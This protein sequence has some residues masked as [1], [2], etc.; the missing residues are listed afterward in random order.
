M[1]VLT[2][3]PAADRA[4]VG[5]PRRAARLRAGAWLPPLIV[6]IAVIGAWYAFSYAVLPADIRFLLPPPHQVVQVGYLDPDNFE[7]MLAALWS[8]TLVAVTGLAIAIVLGMAAGI[9]MSQAR[10]I[11]RSFY[12]YAVILQTIPILALVPLIALWAGYNFPARV[13]V[14]VLI[15]LFPIITNTLFGLQSADSGHHDLFTLHRAGRFT[16]LFKLELPGAMPAIFTGFR[17]SA[18]LS[19]IGAVVGDFFFR[20]GEPGI[21]RILDIY[22]ANLQTEQLFGAVFLAALLGVAVFWFF[23]VLGRLATRHWYDSGRRPQ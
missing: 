15:S 2:R 4:E 1:S 22:R 18:G 23:G 19:V 3:S 10:W 13:I 8:S 9:L 20:Q 6:L 12:P 7:P 5:R 11:E 21:G 17:I 14:C 16:R